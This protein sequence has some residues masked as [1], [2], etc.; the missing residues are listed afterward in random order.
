[1]V[2]FDSRYDTPSSAVTDT[3]ATMG[4]D[5]TAVSKAAAEGTSKEE[6]DYQEEYRDK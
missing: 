1:M 6:A 2:G 3:T 4:L 5:H